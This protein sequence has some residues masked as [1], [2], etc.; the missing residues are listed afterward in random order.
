M[1]RAFWLL[2]FV[3]AVVMGAVLIFGGEDGTDAAQRPPAA[4]AERAAAEAPCSGGGEAGTRVSSGHDVV[5]GPLVLVGG[6]RWAAQKPDAFNGHGYKVPVT[7]P[8]GIQATLLVPASLR[9]R[10]GLVFSLAT[11]ARVAR[12]GVRGADAAV[13]F[14]ACPAQGTPGRTGWPGGLVTDRPRCATLVVQ[15]AGERPVRRRVPLGRPC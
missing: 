8:E 15:A 13:H 5:L 4:G 2:A 9:G 11:Q 7:L 12:S 14:V 6:R 10:V 1:V 3:A